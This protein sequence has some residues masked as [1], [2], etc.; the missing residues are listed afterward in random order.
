VFATLVL[1]FVVTVQ[2]YTLFDKV[3]DTYNDNVLTFDLQAADLA[4]LRGGVGRRRLRGAADRD[5]HLPADLPSRRDARRQIKPV[6][7][8]GM[9]TTPSPSSASSRC[10]R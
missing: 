10:S 4:V 8:G 9:S 1:L 3:R 5:P 6:G 7:V 2:T